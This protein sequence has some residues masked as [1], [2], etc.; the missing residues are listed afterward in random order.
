M[1]EHETKLAFHSPLGG[2]MAKFIH[3]KQ[4]CGYRYDIGICGLR[5]LDRFLCDCGLQNL[6]LPREVVDRWTA[7]RSHERAGTQKL[8]F[9]IVRQFALFVRRQGFEAHVPETRQASVVN[10]DFTPYVFRHEEVKNILEAAD[11]L[12]PDKRTPMRHLIMP[13]LFRLLYCC[14]MRVSEALRLRV[15]DVDLDAGVLT[16]RNAKFNKDRLLP[17]PNSMTMRLQQ[18]AAALGEPAPE[19]IFFPAPDG[20][21]Y[22]TVTIYGV[23]RH[24]LRECG[25]AHRGRGKGPRLH[26]LRHN[27]EFRIIPSSVLRLG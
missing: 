1:S 9:T 26:E 15:A 13:E 23:F 14:G 4:S 11:H 20:G 10:M 27:S 21:S 2:L 16:I 8:R 18:Y 6:E 17:L 5:R 12:P 22:S 7:K 24:L 25:I 19:A 3:E